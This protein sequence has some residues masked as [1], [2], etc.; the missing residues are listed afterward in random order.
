MNILGQSL[1]LIFIIFWFVLSINPT[2]T[3]TWIAENILLFLL[4]IFLVERHKFF[5]LSNLSLVMIFIFAILQTVGS[6]YTY[7]Q[8]PLGFAIQEYF[9]LSRNHYDRFVHFSF[10][11]LL[12]LPLK[13]YLIDKIQ[14]NNKSVYFIILLMLFFGMGGIYE[15]L[16]WG[17]T[18]VSSP[19]ASN[20]FLGEQGDKWDAQK[21]T[22]LGGLGAFIGLCFIYLLEQKRYGRT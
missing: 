2:E 20:E 6:H 4:L 22:A 3:D 1:L 10:G 18:F 5:T 16:E 15:V 21:D 13:E 9:D 11:L 14:I 8:V 19:D 17:Y 12:V 7:A